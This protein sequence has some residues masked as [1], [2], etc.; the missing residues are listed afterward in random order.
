M[1]IY[2]KQ[3]QEGQCFQGG[4]DIA[5]LKYKNIHKY[6]YIFFVLADLYNVG[7][8]D[9]GLLS[10]IPALSSFTGLIIAA[11]LCDYLRNNTR[12]SKPFVSYFVTNLI[13]RNCQ[14]DYDL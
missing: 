5:K 1:K 2:K 4:T 3:G 14:E 8:E 7:I 9:I 12:L 10:G 11:F 13:S 6:T